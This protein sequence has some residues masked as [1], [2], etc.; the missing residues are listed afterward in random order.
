MRRARHFF[1]EQ[2]VA[3][4][5]GA[6]GDDRV[7]LRKMADEAALRVDVEQR[8]DAAI[9][10]G[11]GLFPEPLGRLPAHPRHDA[12]AQD[13][14]DRIGNFKADLGQR[15][16]RRAHDVGHDEHGAPAH[17]ALQHAVQL[18]VDRRRLSPVVGRAGFLFRRRADEG[19]LFD[20]RDIVRVGTMQI[21]TGIFLLVELDQY[22]LPAGFAEQVL[23]LR[24]GTVAPENIFGLRERLDLV[25]PIENCLVGRFFFPDATRRRD[26]GSDVFHGVGPAKAQANF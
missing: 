11:V 9:E 22:S 21:T 19:E 17:R 8:M 5:T 23:V 7:V 15:R 6:D 18:A 14:I 20:A 3:A 12:H 4:V 25:H 10:L 2:D 13:D 1:A 16:V 26:G 24:L